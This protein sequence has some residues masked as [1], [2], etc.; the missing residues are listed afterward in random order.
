MRRTAALVVAV[1]SFVVVPAA[2]AL[3]PQLAGLQVALRSYGLYGGAVDGIAGPRTVAA[4]RAFQR[5]HGLP[6]TGR[7]DLR[8]RRALGSLGRPLFGRRPLVRGRFGWDV[9]VLQFLLARRGFYHGGLDGYFD[10]DT[11]RALRAYQRSMRLRADGVAG[12]RT[13]LAFAI[14]SRVAVAPSQR[15]ATHRYHVHPGDTLS[16][17]SRRYGTSVR[18]LARL[19]RLDPRGMLLAG[20]WLR[21]PRSTTR[22]AS[23]PTTVRAMLDSAAARYGVDVHLVRAVAWMESGYQTNVTSPAGA[24][25]VMQVLPVTWQYVEHILLGRRIP[26]TTRGNITV[27]VAYLRQLLREFHGNTELA[28][29]AWYQGPASVRRHGVHAGT[30]T[31]TANVLALRQRL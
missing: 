21:V 11:Q 16:A 1:A 7:A 31:F 24:W 12:R 2:A 20:T 30:R 14:G 25:G 4:V 19:N 15:L 17:I 5:R 23:S 26:R 10:A 18:E 29:A 13:F 3:N 8:T 6:V 28:L 27:G 9:S 22:S